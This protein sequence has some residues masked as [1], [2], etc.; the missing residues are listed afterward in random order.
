[1]QPEAQPS[2]WD[3]EY[4][5]LLLTINA[6]DVSPLDVTTKDGGGPVFAVQISAHQKTFPDS[7]YL[8]V[9]LSLLPPTV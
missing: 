5:G 9:L 8:L 4:D 7:S 2:L 1:M 6:S 3:K